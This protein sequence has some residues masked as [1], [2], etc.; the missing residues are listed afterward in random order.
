MTASDVVDRC[1]DQ[2]A[3][4]RLL[5][6]H[7]QELERFEL[8]LIEDR[9]WTIMNKNTSTI[10]NLSNLSPLRDLRSVPAYLFSP[11]AR[12]FWLQS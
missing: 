11:S 12:C 8:V 3:N 9:P 2:T 1:L 10:V 7:A 6:N 5:Q 4:E